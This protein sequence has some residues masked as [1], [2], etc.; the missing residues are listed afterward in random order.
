[1]VSKATENLLASN[2]RDAMAYCGFEVNTQC[3]AKESLGAVEK[4]RSPSQNNEMVSKATE[5]GSAS[6]IRDAM[7][8]AYCGFEVDKYCFAKCNKDQ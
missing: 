4:T 3:F 5:N 6:N 2:I 7:H 8:M 1:M